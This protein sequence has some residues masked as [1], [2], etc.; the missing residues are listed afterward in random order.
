[1]PFAQTGDINIYYERTG[2][3]PK[4]LYI[5]GTGHDLRRPTRV[6]NTPLADS[7]DLLSYD[8]RGLGQTDKPDAPYSMAQYAD[9]AARLLDAVGWDRCLVHGTSFGGMVAQELALRH[10]GRVEKLVLCCCAA[11]GA[12]GASYPLHELDHMEMHEKLLFRLG[13]SDTRLDA[14]WQAANPDELKKRIAEQQALQA[15]GGDDADRAMGEHRQ[16]DARAR[17]DT[18][19]R[20]PQ[21]ELPVL[22]CGGR[23]DGQAAPAAVEALA[24]RIKGAQLNWFEG[25]HG[26]QAQDPAALEAISAFLL[27]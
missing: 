18:W 7:F 9:D 20:L 14:A 10:P 4:L 19:D 25:G 1:M 17:H 8:Q 23:Y 16:L 12:G 21:L 3:G 26:F 13:I 5:S 2:A 22:V 6:F 15:I 27:G 11:G 24:G